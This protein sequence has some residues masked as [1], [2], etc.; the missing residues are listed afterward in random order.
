MTADGAD[1]GVGEDADPPGRVPGTM[2]LFGGHG[3]PEG[4]TCQR[5][6]RHGIPKVAHAGPRIAVMFRPRWGATYEAWSL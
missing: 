1:D 2:C 3:G 4:G 6:W 5:T